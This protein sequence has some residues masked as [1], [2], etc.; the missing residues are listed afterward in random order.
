LDAAGSLTNRRIKTL[1]VPVEESADRVSFAVTHPDTADV[2]L[3]L[4]D[5]DGNEVDTSPGSAATHVASS[6]PH[7]FIVVNNPMPGRWTVLAVRPRPGPAFVARVVAGGENR[8]LQVFVRTAPVHHA[9]Q[10]V[11]LFASARW[12]HELTRLRVTARI[13]APSG[14]RHSIALTDTLDGSGSGTGSGEY[15]GVFTPVEQGRHHA[16]V[17]ISGS[18]AASLANPYRQLSHFPGTSFDTSLEVPRFVRQVVIDFYV[19]KPPRPRRRREKPRGS[20]PG[21]P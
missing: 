11:P 6:A 9:G 14:A 1:T 10:P 19:G 15:S 18:A 17:T 20:V 2:W 12:G 16:L 7:E 4:L 3:Y 5:P 13:T 21:G 8:H